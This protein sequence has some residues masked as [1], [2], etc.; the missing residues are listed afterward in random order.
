MYSLIQGY[1]ERLP[2][3]MRPVEEGSKEK[4]CIYTPHSLRATTATLLL[5]SGVELLEVQELLGHSE[6][7]TTA[8][9]LHSDTRTKQAAVGKLNGLLRLAPAS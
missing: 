9:Y 1:L 3:A 6:L 5:K 8:K 4:R 2:R 7:E